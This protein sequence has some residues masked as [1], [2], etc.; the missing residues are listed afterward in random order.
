MMVSLYLFLVHTSPIGTNVFLIDGFSTILP[1]FLESEKFSLPVK[2]RFAFVLNVFLDLK[3][4]FFFF[5]F[6][7]HTCSIWKFL[8]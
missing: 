6:Y 1:K 3:G 7:S 4:F 8:G 2:Y 5:P